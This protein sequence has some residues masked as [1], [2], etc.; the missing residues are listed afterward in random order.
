MWRTDRRQPIRSHLGLFLVGVNKKFERSI[1]VSIIY[2]FNY[3]F[4]ALA[5]N[6]LSLPARRKTAT[7]GEAAAAV[8][9]A[10]NSLMFFRLA[11]PLLD[12][13]FSERHSF[14]LVPP[15]KLFF[16]LPAAESINFWQLCFRLY[17]CPGSAAWNRKKVKLQEGEKRWE[18]YGSEV[19]AETAH[20]LWKSRSFE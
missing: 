17:R 6:L 20:G 5:E 7:A 1:I 8:A 9:T 15:L 11:R 2:L 4:V 19:S 3:L 12:P 16:F 14:H 18:R 13:S 10:V